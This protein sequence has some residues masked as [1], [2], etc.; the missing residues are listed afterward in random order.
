VEPSSTFAHANGRIV[1]GP[2]LRQRCSQR[3]CKSGFD[4]ATM[5]P[6]RPVC[7]RSLVEPAIRPPT[8]E[9]QESP[10]FRL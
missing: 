8:S 3:E 2:V 1:P 10:Q 4:A 9:R 6:D 5:S 7:R